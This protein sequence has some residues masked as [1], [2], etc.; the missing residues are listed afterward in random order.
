[1]PF[2]LSARSP[3]VS[4]QDTIRGTCILGAVSESGMYIKRGPPLY[5]RQYCNRLPA[6]V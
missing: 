2:R 5:I 6:G 3:F 4:G 1:M